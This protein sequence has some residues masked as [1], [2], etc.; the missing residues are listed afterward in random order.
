MYS[1]LNAEIRKHQGDFGGSKS[2]DEIRRDYDTLFSSD[3]LEV[4]QDICG[5]QEQLEA[6]EQ[7]CD[8]FQVIVISN[9]K[10]LIQM[11]AVPGSFTKK[12]VWP[13]HT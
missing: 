13:M 4:L 11:Y 12:R 10:H 7:L 9:T 2:G 5:R 1:E 3:I 8:I 6:R